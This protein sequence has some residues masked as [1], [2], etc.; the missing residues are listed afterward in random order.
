M[1]NLIDVFEIRFPRLVHETKFGTKHPTIM[2]TMTRSTTIGF[3]FAALPILLMTAAALNFDDFGFF[4]VSFFALAF[5]ASFFM[6]LSDILIPSPYSNCVARNM[7]FSW[8]A[9]SPSIKPVTRPS[10]ITMMRSDMPMSSPI[11]DEIM[12]MLFPCFARSA[13]M[14]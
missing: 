8:V 4:A 12:M 14:Q 13:M 7:M 11:S 10:H 1:M 6:I 9:L 2:L 3:D 5:P